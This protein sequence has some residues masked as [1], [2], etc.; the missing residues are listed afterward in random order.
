MDTKLKNTD[1][2]TDSYDDM[3]KDFKKIKLAR[4]IVLI[5]LS[6]LI[7]LSYI[8]TKDIAVNRRVFKEINLYGYDYIG[9]DIDKFT[10]KVVAFGELYK[11]EEYAKEPKN[12]T[13]QEMGI[14]R[15]WAKNKINDEY[16]E[17]VNALHENQTQDWTEKRWQ[18]E[19]DKIYNE[20]LTKY[21]YDDEGLRKLISDTKANNFSQLNNYLN[22]QAN[23]K[24]IIY[25]RAN[26]I[27][28]SNYKNSNNV[29]EMK[30]ESRFFA[31]YHLD[32][33]SV[34]RAIYVYGERVTERELNSV[35]YNNSHSSNIT[36]IETT[37]D[38]G[39]QYGNYTTGFSVNGNLAVYISVPRDIVV[40]DS[41]YSGLEEYGRAQNI[42][43][44]QITGLIIGLIGVG[45]ILIVLKKM[46]YKGSHFQILIDKL[47]ELPLE[48]NILGLLVMFFIKAMFFHYDWSNPYRNTVLVRNIL[49]VALVIMAVYLVAKAMYLK[50]KD[51][52]LF[53]GS[54]LIKFYEN[55][56]ICLEKKSFGRKLFLILAIYIVGL[57]VGALFL[58]LAFEEAGAVFAV[59]SFI[60]ATAIGIFTTVRD[61][62]Y[63]NTI[64]KGA[65][66]I[67]EGKSSKNIPEKRKGA[68]RDLAHSI[69]NMKEGLRVSIDNETKSERMKTELITNVS[70][71]LK[72]PL[73]SIINYVDL[74][75][76]IDVQPEEA[77]V[78]VEVLDKKSQRLKILIE[79][80]FEASKAAS[81]SM[82]LNLEKIDVSALLRQTLGE[83]EGRIEKARLNFKVA[84]PKEKIYIEGDG[85]KLWRVFENLVNNIIKYSLEGTRVYIDMKKVEDNV[86]ISMK[87]ISA[88]EMSFNPEEITERF[89]RGEESR[90]TEGSGLGLAIAKSI[91]AL[92][93]GNLKVDVEA[94]LFKVQVELKTI[95][96]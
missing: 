35:Y 30:D 38:G 49:L 34:Q 27:W 33:G 40:G 61:F 58:I 5:I 84:M 54:Y 67:C 66:D 80:L 15:E 14:A 57:G 90:H 21:G 88:T 44:N 56:M 81:G 94:D 2:K 10:K 63:L 82:Q 26:N 59:V 68:L 39:D 91:V 17:R 50:Y 6:M 45:I 8:C 25:D 74:L 31:E 76:R 36:S 12:V 32:G 43:N 1:E 95:E 64:T 24:Y 75:K 28:M 4:T 19:Q 48:V 96:N 13:E 60:L 72:T 23:L 52:N 78:Y 53:E 65:K 71:D 89:K 42:T 9:D 79:D 22:S 85:R 11:N 69:N 77:K 29:D 92:H 37:I 62:A 86:V 55:V 7:A 87:N 70:H 16:E 51:G 20:L 3:V 46:K 73:T 47:K 18:E 93:G 41:I 83:A